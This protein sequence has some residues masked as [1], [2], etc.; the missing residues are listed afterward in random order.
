MMPAQSP[1]SPRGFEVPA[2]VF[3]KLHVVKCGSRCEN[4]RIAGA[5]HAANHL[6]D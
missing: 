2:N 6:R 1:N 4:M 3:W 5:T